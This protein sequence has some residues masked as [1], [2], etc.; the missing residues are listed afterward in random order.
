MI[1]EVKIPSPGESINEVVIS[2][3]FKK[4]GDLIHQDED[5][6]EIES[7]KATL[8]IAS[9]GTGKLEILCQE[10]ETVAVEQV[11]AKIDTDVVPEEQASRESASVPKSTQP[12]T[13]E[14]A[15][16]HYAKG[17]ASVAAGKIMRE[18]NVNSETVFGSGKNGRITKQ[19]VITK[20]EATTTDQPE[21]ETL[22][23]LA[24]KTSQRE[25]S[26]DKL[27]PLRKKIATRLVAAK[28]ETA[29]LTTFN[30][31]NMSQVMKIRRDHKDPFF[32]KHGVKLGFM[33]FFT[34]ALAIALN[35]YPALNAYIV[36]DEIEY[37]GY[38]DIGISVSTPKGL[39]V[40]VIRNAE[41]LS[42]ADLE[43]EILRLADKARDLKLSIDEMTGGTFTITNGGVFG[44]L[45]ST[46]ILNPPQSGI[47]GMHNIVERPIAVNGE[48]KIQPMMYVA[49][50][51]DHRIVD[52][53]ESV[54]FLRKVKTL[55]EDPVG[56]LLDL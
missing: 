17:V 46:P 30:E 33:S 22:E 53:R 20:S 21:A 56:F 41:T 52:G 16:T 34:K 6:I 38:K 36:G 51:Y 13:A 8:T 1:I 2:S 19:D 39:L 12:A 48:I 49:L 24:P 4:T 23:A 35:D 43:K 54:S 15:K 5:L 10:G 27:S 50:S 7:E 42:V 31:I 47:L 40:P 18:Q 37:H 45:M 44:S 9:E 3:W 32:Q 26:Y 25:I 28:N 11:V 14:P 55:I 29:M